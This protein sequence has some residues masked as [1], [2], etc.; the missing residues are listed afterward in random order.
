[1]EKRES[2]RHDIN[3]SIVCSYVSAVRFSETF[4]G[5]MKNCCNNGMYAEL[6]AHFK[7]GTILVVRTTGRSFGYSK[8]DGFRSLALAEVKWSQR[9]PVQGEVCYGT[10]L[11]YLMV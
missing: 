9:R 1:M 7:T 11:K 10:G 8:E 6:R 2:I 4:Q 5:R 3:T